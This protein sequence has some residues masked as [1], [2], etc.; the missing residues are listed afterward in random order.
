MPERF[1]G[2][3]LAGLRV[4]SSAVTGLSAY[5]QDAAPVSRHL[6]E[7]AEATKPSPYATLL[8]TYRERH[9]RAGPSVSMK[10]I[11]IVDD[12]PLIR[13][14]VR[15]VVEEAGFVVKEAATADEALT[16]VE[17]ARIDIVLSD[18]EMPGLLDGV[19]LARL[20]RE[21]WPHMTVIL[22]SGRRLPRKEE[23][24][25]NTRFLA[26]PFSADS[27]LDALTCSTL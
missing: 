4:G 26:K 14:Y 5:R 18:V 27:L 16:L 15:D 12:E 3:R 11:L 19:A 24:P 10:V 22:A 9:A 20:V 6:L 13:M 17:G 25:E 21:R 7:C 8:F 1:A 2:A 23:M